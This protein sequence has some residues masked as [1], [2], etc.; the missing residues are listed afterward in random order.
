MFETYYPRNFCKDLVRIKG[1]SAQLSMLMAVIFGIKPCMDDWISIERYD[2]YKAACRKYGLL[3]RESSVFYE[4]NKRFIYAGVVGRE[5]LTTT[6]AL[7]YRYSPNV[8]L[9]AGVVHVFISRTH[10]HL[11]RCFQNGWYPVIVN[12]R[13]IDKPLADVYGFGHTLGYP[14]CCIDF[15]RKFNN[16]LKYSYLHEV[17]KNTKVSGSLPYVCNP[18]SK[19]DTYTYIY[20]MPCSYSCINTK[21]TALS[22]RKA[23]M[24]KEPEF[25]VAIDRHLKIPYLV[26]YER[27]FFAFE[28]SLENGVI[29]YNKVYSLSSNRNISENYLTSLA[30][31]DAVR[32]DDRDIYVSRKGKD[33]A[34]IRTEKKKFGPEYPF[35]IQFSS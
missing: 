1:N 25:V 28:G 22:L 21:E 34:V 7:G 29:R 15:F 20:H 3:V 17:L 33:V 2:A 4:V 14:P 8:R 30:K 9:R 6:C 10:Q 26:V 23:I 31:G 24:D 19:D 12:N 11:E 35:I 18:F 16:W 32:V 5:R 13:V 27:K